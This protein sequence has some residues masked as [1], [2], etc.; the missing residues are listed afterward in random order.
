[1]NAIELVEKNNHELLADLHR[2]MDLGGDDLMLIV[3]K[4]IQSLAE[5]DTLL[6]SFALLGFSIAAASHKGIRKINGA[7]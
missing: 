1:M 7:E 4:N 5:A 6:A 2:I 3:E